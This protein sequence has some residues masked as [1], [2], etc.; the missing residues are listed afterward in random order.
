MD[1][2]ALKMI[3]SIMKLGENN[4]N[5]ESLIEKQHYNIMKPT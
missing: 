3:S 1:K 5:K 4:S 2:N